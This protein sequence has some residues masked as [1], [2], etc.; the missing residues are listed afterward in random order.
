MPLGQA[1]PAASRDGLGV[2]PSPGT[3]LLHVSDGAY[4]LTCA[5]WDIWNES[6]NC[7]FA[8]IPFTGTEG[9]FTCRVTAVTNVSCPYLSPWAK[10]GLMARGDL[11]DN[12]A[13]VTIEGSGANGVA[14]Q[15]RFAANLAPAAQGAFGATTSGGFLGASGLTLDN[16]KPAKNYIKQPFW[17]QL[18]RRGL[19]WSFYTSLDGQKW[20]E[21]GQPYTPEMGGCWV[22]IF[23]DSGNFQFNGKGA[24][25]VTFDHLS[26]T[27]TTVV[28]V[29]VAS[30]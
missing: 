3:G 5:G 11:S 13:D 15:M 17:L 27:P 14:T 16:T 4:T 25:A 6:D 22:G 23:A 20:V 12:A 19:T 10:F 24:I 2:P 1:Y 28:Q 18:R 30:S 8:A 7:A 21:A 29:G 9:A 26:F